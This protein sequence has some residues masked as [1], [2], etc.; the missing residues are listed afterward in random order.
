MAGP[1]KKWLH[2]CGDPCREHGPVQFLWSGVLTDALLRSCRS[3]PKGFCA[4][5]ETTLD[6]RPVLDS[7][8][9]D[10]RFW[11]SPATFSAW[12]EERMHG[13]LDAIICEDFA[14]VTRAVA[15]RTR[16]L[17]VEGGR[18]GCS[19]EDLGLGRV[20][21]QWQA[22]LHPIP[23]LRAMGEGGNVGSDRF[24]TSVACLCDHVSGRV[25]D[26]STL[27]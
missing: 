25:G 17:G 9:L 2:Q 22:T 16:S 27:Q 24:E 4:M 13:G 10:N 15:Q 7:W 19:P 14:D 11:E 20:C 1:G 6:P 12:I 26:Q 21:R 3:F 23:I 18:A 5:T 8:F